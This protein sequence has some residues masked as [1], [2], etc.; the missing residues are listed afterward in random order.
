MDRRKTEAIA[1]FRYRLISPIICRESLYFGETAELIREA[2]V[3]I[4]HIPGSRKTRVTI[5]VKLLLPWELCKNQ[6]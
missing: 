4:Y 2:A 1:N 5:R 3:K 6:H